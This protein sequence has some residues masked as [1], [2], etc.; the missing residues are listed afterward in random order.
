ME[1]GNRLPLPSG[2]VSQRA[3]QL[4]GRWFV[5]VLYATVIA[6]AA[7]TGYFI[8]SFRPEGLDPRLFGVVPFPPTPLGMAAYGAITLA[9]VLGV[10]IGGVVLVSRR[11]VDE[12]GEGEAVGARGQD[13]GDVES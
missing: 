10:F 9:V 4:A 2:T 8:G 12:D 3:P 6:I 13:D 1:K 5:A 7:G 11:Y